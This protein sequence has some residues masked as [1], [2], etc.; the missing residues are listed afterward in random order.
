MF[1]V[2]S[3]CISTAIPHS[4]VGVVPGEVGDWGW[5]EEH[6]KRRTAPVWQSCCCPVHQ[7]SRSGSQNCYCAGQIWTQWGSKSVERLVMYLLWG[8][9]A[10]HVAK[11]K[12]IVGRFDCEGLHQ[13]QNCLLF[14]V[15]SATVYFYSA[16]LS[17]PHFHV[18]DITVISSVYKH[19][20]IHI[21]ICSRRVACIYTCSMI[22]YDL[23][24]C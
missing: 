18:H 3:L 14:I 19:C 7:T 15:N 22:Q 21:K 1:C 20:N 13:L 12:L 17:I 24:V 6:E 10:I 5:S 11:R 8:I 23:P 16:I 9:W 4:P 2:S